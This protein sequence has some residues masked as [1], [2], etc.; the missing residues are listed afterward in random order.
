[1][2]RY[3]RERLLLVALGATVLVIVLRWLA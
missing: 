1:M 3:R 2:S